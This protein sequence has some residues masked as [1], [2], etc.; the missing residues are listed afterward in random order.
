MLVRNGHELESCRVPKVPEIESTAASGQHGGATNPQEAATGAAT[1]TPTPPTSVAETHIALVDML[2][3]DIR[4]GQMEQLTGIER[5]QSLG[6]PEPSC[7]ERHAN[8]RAFRAA[9]KR[10]RVHRSRA[11]EAHAAH[12]F[13]VSE[14]EVAAIRA[15]CLQHCELSAAI[16][17]RRRRFPGITN[18]AQAR[19]NAPRPSPPRSHCQY[20]F[21]GPGCLPTRGDS[22]RARSRPGHTATLS[23]EDVAG[24]RAPPIGPV[25][26]ASSRRPFRQAGM[27]LD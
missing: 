12:M 13:I 6:T 16:E 20:H 2:I 21:A 15:V 22:R 5:P 23:C 11:W 4:P 19:G 17:V 24:A 10:Y 7:Q 14:A 26:R 18:T 25:I 1:A 3:R 27:L 9:E 8:H